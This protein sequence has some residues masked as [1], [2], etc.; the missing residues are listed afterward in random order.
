MANL[1]TARILPGL[2]SEYTIVALPYWAWFWLDDHVQTN[3]P[4]G[5][6]QFLSSLNDKIESEDALAD[7]LE[8]YATVIQSSAM[9]KVYN[10]AN[11]NNFLCEDVKRRRVSGRPARQIQDVKLPAIYKLFGFMPCATTLEA[12]W[13]RRHYRR[14]R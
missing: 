11:D 10:L 12:V 13:E 8:T 1:K 5:Y 2:Q 9:R 3:Y 7:H 4:R 14:M 6:S